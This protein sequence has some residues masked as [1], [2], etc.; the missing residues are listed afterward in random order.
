MASVDIQNNKPCQL[1]IRLQNMWK[2]KD[3]SKAWPV[4]GVQEKD[5]VLKLVS[6]TNES[7]TIVDLFKFGNGANE[8]IQMIVNLHATIEHVN[9]TLCGLIKLACDNAFQKI[10]VMNCYN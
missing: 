5:C 1:T 10:R 8:L 2:D 7:H 3:T 4:K 9:K 6:R